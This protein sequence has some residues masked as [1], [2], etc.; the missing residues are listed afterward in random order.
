VTPPHLLLLVGINLIF[1]FN[2]I[3]S[4]Y[5]M[6]QLPPLYFTGLRFAVVAVV[7]WPLLRLPRP[8][9]RLILSIALTV[10][11]LH[12]GL[13]YLGLALAEDISTVAIALQMVVPF[14]TLLGVLMLGERIGWRRITGMALA[15]AGVLLIAFD[16]RVLGYLGAL[17]LVLLGA[18]AMALGTIYMKRL[19]RV[20]PLEL[21]AWIGLV[22]APSLLLL[23][24]VFE[25][26]QWQATV[27]A[28]SMSWAAVVF[29]ALGSSVVAHAGLYWL[30]Q[31]YEVSLVSPLMLLST[32]F[33]VSFGIWLMGDVLTPAI[34]V[35]GLATLTGV[36]VIA[37]RSGRSA[38]VPT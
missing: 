34:I 16:P 29:S 4:K 22:G 28:D 11:V 25:Q 20:Q 7:L 5:G 38:R 15:F 32:V 2:L 9:L 3:A 17:G 1:G 13:I 8:Q 19:S 23:S 36:A 12:F 6:A 35:G 33:S 27:E 21:Q 37:A 18:L 30:I 14:T 10:G 26:G 31:R 24:L